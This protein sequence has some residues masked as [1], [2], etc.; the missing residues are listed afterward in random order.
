MGQIPESR[1]APN[2]LLA[3]GQKLLSRR[4]TGHPLFLAVHLNR[5][6]QLG[7]LAR[8]PAST[9][10]LETVA[11]RIVVHLKPTDRYALAAHDEIWVIIDGIGTQDE[12]L[13]LA[14]RFRDALSTP[15]QIETEH[16]TLT[17][18]VDPLIGA[19]WN[20]DPAVGI[21]SLLQSAWD[22][23]GA[24]AQT[25][26]RV[27]ITKL[28]NQESV[29]RQTDLYQAV[30]RNLFGNELEVHFQPQIN[31][32]TTHCVAAEALIRWP[33]DQQIQV[34]ASQIVTIC[35]SQ[36][37]M[38][39][40]TQFVVNAALR[41]HLRWK[42]RGLDI[43]VSINLSARS[44][45]DTAFP[46][47]VASSCSAWGVSPSK[48]VFELTEGAIVDHE[49]SA[50]ECLRG[51]NSLGC[52]IS[53]DDF[54]TGFASVGFLRRFPVHELK[55]DRTFIQNLRRERSDQQIVRAL[56]ELAH[57][58]DIRV[59]A[60]GVE[61]IQTEIM[62]RDAGCELAHGFL[63][64][65]AMPPDQFVQWVNDNASQ[66]SSTTIER[67]GVMTALNGASVA[68]GSMSRTSTSS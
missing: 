36:G 1:L 31:L 27:L 34:G 38:G 50:L 23:R 22:A 33:R 9:R 32:N 59:L 15:I 55:I 57:A 53:L 52:E 4:G 18:R 45:H 51:L 40:L 68:V 29:T 3:H 6:D 61:D 42:A 43:K 41:H 24:A 62:L 48:L 44:I 37:L 2:E 20:P 67:D 56:I 58:F 28:G 54:G 25:P 47:Q 8:E 49:Q 63:Y 14:E 21:G 13:A 66:R 16:D 17:A 60:E 39:Q 46:A 7:A 64:S 11:S 26:K 30:R 5:S 19:A 12:S 65:R 35:E 10:V